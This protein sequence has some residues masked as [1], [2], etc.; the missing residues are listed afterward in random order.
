MI[1]NNN[2]SKKHN[3]ETQNNQ[4]I[5]IRSKDVLTVIIPIQ[6]AFSLG[7]QEDMDLLRYDVKDG[8][9]VIKKNNSIKMGGY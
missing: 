6:A 8:Q 7:I 5:A 3:E 9:L 4:V 2:Q 1:R